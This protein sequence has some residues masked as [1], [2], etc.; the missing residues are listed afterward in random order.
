MKTSPVLDL[1]EDARKDFPTL[2][3]AFKHVAGMTKQSVLSV[4]STYYRSRRG[5]GACN[6]NRK[7]LPEQETTLVGVAQAFSVSNVAMS[8]AQLRD[9]VARNYGIAVSKMW[10]TRFVR[11]HLQQLSKRAC[12][13]LDDKRVGQRVYD[14]VFD[15]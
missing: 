10:V 2:K 13:A 8:S 4:K 9:L 11:R 7:L 14:G 12:K 6:A 3:A 5:S 1:V 15:F